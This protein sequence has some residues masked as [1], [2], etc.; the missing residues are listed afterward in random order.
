MNIHIAIPL[1]CKMLYFCVSLCA[2]LMYLYL[3]YVYNIIC[4]VHK[5]CVWICISILLYYVCCT[6]YL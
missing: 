5:V 3:L 6:L 4:V 1:I 2:I